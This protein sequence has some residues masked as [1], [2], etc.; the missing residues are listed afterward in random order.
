MAA[1][2]L[3]ALGPRENELRLLPPADA[4]ETPGRDPRSPLVA[5]PTKRRRIDV[6]ELGNRSRELHGDLT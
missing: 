6:P 4:M 5:R 2:T 3:I 1:Q